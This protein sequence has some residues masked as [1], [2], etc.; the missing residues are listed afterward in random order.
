LITRK[1]RKPD[2]DFGCGRTENS[3]PKGMHAPCVVYRH[4]VPAIATSKGQT[5]IG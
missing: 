2:A 3:F 5:M 1:I 4:I